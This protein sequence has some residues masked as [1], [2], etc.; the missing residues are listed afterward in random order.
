MKE[1][2]IEEYLKAEI[3]KR[4]SEDIVSMPSEDGWDEL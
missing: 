3:E 1:E 4:G 2:K